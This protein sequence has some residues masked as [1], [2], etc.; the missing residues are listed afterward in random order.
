MDAR[1]SRLVGIMPPGDR[2]GD[3]VDWSH[4]RRHFGFDL[5]A[6]Y[7]EFV[8]VYGGGTIN[9]SFHVGLPFET[10][11]R[12]RGARH[13]EELTDDGLSLVEESD[14]IQ[15][16]SSECVCWAADAQANFVFWRLL[17]SNPDAW[18][19]FV[20][21]RDGRIIDYDYSMIEF[22]LALI[23]GESPRP[24]I[25]VFS[26]EDPVFFNWKSEMALREAGIDPWPD[27]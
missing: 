3:A 1:L 24:P 6:D 9:D 27:I 26:P 11:A 5:P 2:A 25:T 16:S 8:A 18:P 17:G 7:R 13:L 10:E 12:H 23:G 4:V 22:M 15:I 21:L 14:S 19:V 20:V